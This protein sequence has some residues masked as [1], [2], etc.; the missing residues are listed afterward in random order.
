MEKKIS[1]EAAEA[2]RAYQN[3]WRR[4]NKKRVQEY[5]VIYWQRKAEEFARR[6]AGQE[7]QA[8]ETKDN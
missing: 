3:E 1:A 4:K 5:N 7:A 8:D 2:R 6:Q